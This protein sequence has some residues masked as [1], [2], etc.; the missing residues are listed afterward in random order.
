MTTDEQI[1]VCKAIAKSCMWGHSGIASVIVDKLQESL[2]TEPYW[3]QLYNQNEKQAK[4]EAVGVVKYE[5]EIDRYIHLGYLLCNYTPGELQFHIPR[6][7]GGG[8]FK[9]ILGDLA[10]KYGEIY[11]PYNFK[12]VQ[13]R[14]AAGLPL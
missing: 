3:Q 4:Y 6:I 1:L 14:K 11:D 12:C 7:Y 5:E 10:D 13:H 9:Y 8:L 2:P